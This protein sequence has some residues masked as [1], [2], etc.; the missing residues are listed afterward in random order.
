MRK[1]IIDDR[2]RGFASSYMTDVQNECPNVVTDLENLKTF[3]VANNV[4]I[5]SSA[6][7][8]YIDTIIADY[9]AL[10][11]LEPKNWDLQK[12]KD[13]EAREPG[14]LKKKVTY[15]F[16]SNGKAQITELYKRIV[17][18]MRYTDVRVILGSIHQ[19]MGLKSC[20][21]CN[22]ETTLTGLDGDVFYQMDHFLPKSKY[23]FLCTC[24]YNLQPSCGGCNGH[25]LTQDSDFGLYVN[26]EQGIEINPFLFV[27]Q[28]TDIKGMGDYTCLSIGFTGKS[29]RETT[30]SKEHN[31]VFHIKSKYSGHRD[32]VKDIYDEAYKMTESYINATHDAYGV[33][34]MKQDVLA[35]M[36]KFP[37]EEERI[38]EKPFTKLKQDTMKQLKENGLL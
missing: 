5:D 1:L 27:P 31:K 26:V 32:K 14:M 21:Y 36:E 30:E 34:P 33:N 24:F 25:K 28:V 38:H 2:I 12:Y 4:W 16:D 18:C 13:V 6:V 7:V 10:L 37:L 3:V 35:F 29:K 20:V 15:G 19:E 22:A 17:F 8:D 23:P 9:P 11:T